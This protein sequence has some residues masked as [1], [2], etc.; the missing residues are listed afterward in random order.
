LADLGSQ[1]PGE[2]INVMAFINNS[3]HDY[4]SN[5]F[6]GGLNPGQNNL[7]SDGF[8]NYEVHKTSFDLTFHDGNQYFEVTNVPEPGASALA[9]LGILGA[10]ALGRR[11]SKISG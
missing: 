9:G 7:G 4:V 1:A 3:N 2:T 10:A 11:R 6:L 5:Q 8:G